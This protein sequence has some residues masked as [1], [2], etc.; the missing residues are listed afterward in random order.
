LPALLAILAFGCSSAQSPAED[1][2][3]E[4]STETGGAGGANTG[5]GGQKDAGAPKVDA[6][7]GGKAAGGSTGSGGKAAGGSTGSGG[8]AAGG[9]TGSGGA[10]GTGG[11]TGSGGAT[12]TGGSVGTG[13]NGTG[14][15]TWDGG[16]LTTVAMPLISYN[17]PAFTGSG[18]NSNPAKA[19]DDDPMT[20]WGPSTLPGWLAYDLSKVPVAQRQSVLVAWNAEHSGCYLCTPAAYMAMPIDYTIEINTAASAASAPTT[21]WTEVA[22]VTGE[23]HGTFEIPVALAGANW[24]RVSVSKGSDP[25]G[26]VAIE[27]DVF[28]TPSG[29]TDSWLFMGDSIT[30]MTMQYPWNDLPQLVHK[31]RADRWPAVIDAAIGGTNT[32]TAMAVID[33]TMAGF[34]GRYVVLAYG[35]NDHSNE[36]HMEELV[37]HVIAAGKV[38]VV[39]HMPWADGKLTEGPLINAQIDALYVKYPAI[40]KGPDLWAAFL[41]RTDYIAAGDVHPNGAGQEYLRGLWATTMAAVP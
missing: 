20:T 34:P 28:S 23:T 30:Y 31:A 32:T 29:A 40:L 33:A 10:T 2:V 12:G 35:T 15:M 13:G 21:G 1:A 41:N 3:D 4:T 25:A 22:R 7:S 36:L 5:G 6:G 19:N 18:A 11:K 38:P 8:K 26:G 14:G 39:P 16:P 37:Q 27:F 24:I 17:V 9:S